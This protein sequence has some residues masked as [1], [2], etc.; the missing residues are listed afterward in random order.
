MT[1]N[2]EYIH[3][4]I[5][6]EKKQEWTKPCLEMVR[7]RE[8][9]DSAGIGWHDQ[10]VR[11][12][13]HTIHR[14]ISDAMVVVNEDGEGLEFRAFSV[15]WG[16]FTYGGTDGLLEVWPWYADDP[17]G[18]LGAYEA[19]ELCAEAIKRAKEARS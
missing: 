9:L 1:K 18:H 16:Q 12:G 2:D 11:N 7:L 6:R 14:T 3:F 8:L 15:V 5:E 17:T 10:S 19:Y 13:N 4:L